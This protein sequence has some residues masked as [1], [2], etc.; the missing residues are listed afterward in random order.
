MEPEGFCALRDAGVFSNLQPNLFE[1]DLSG[2][3]IIYSGGQESIDQVVAQQ[4]PQMAS[5]RLGSLF[6]R[7]GHAAADGW[8]LALS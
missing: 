8:L 7:V 6:S 1:V 3:A 4:G 2:N 5:V